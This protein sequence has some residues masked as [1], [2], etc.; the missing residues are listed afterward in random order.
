MVDSG[1]PARSPGMSST[2]P[3]PSIAAHRSHKSLVS[4]PNERTEIYED[5][6][7][8]EEDDEE[9]DDDESVPPT[10][11]TLPRSH[12]PGHLASKS[13]NDRS[14]GA[15]AKHAAELAT[16]QRSHPRHRHRQP[17]RR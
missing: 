3:S 13:V 8:S 2:K 17:A 7:D 11:Q 1:K 12:T 4:S 10:Y 9:E 14:A 16:R 6:D 5:S 15:A